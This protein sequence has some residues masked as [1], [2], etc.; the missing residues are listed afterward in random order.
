MSL[1]NYEVGA[2]MA[3]ADL[4]KARDFYEKKLGLKVRNEVPDD[5]FVSYECGGGTGINVYL[6]PEH[7]GKATATMAG[8]NVDDLEKVVEE[9]NSNGVTF[10]QYDDPPLVTDEQG[11]IDFGENKVAF[12]RDPDGNTHALNEGM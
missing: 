2:V 6:S 5:G 1:S 11:I 10:E 8:W 12:F 3:T 9:L 4:T 7:A